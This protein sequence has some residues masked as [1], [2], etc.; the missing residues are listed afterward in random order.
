MRL[1]MPM[2]V[3]C[4]VLRRRKNN[5]VLDEHPK[6]LRALMKDGEWIYDD[7]GYWSSHEV[8]HWRTLP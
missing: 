8:T 2:S 7:V 4:L 3:R 1:D 5:D 6:M